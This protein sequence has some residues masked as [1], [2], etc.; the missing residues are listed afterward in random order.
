LPGPQQKPP[1]PKNRSKKTRQPPRTT[2][3]R[4]PK[5]KNEPTAKKQI[6][7]NT[8]NKR[9]QG[10]EKKR[11]H[12]YK[13]QRNKARHHEQGK[14]TEKPRKER[15]TKKK[16][17]TK[18]NDR[19]FEPTKKHTMPEGKRRGNLPAKTRQKREHQIKELLCTGLTPRQIWSYLKKEGETSGEP[20][21]IKESSIHHWTRRAEAQLA[22]ESKIN[23]ETELGKATHRLNQ[24]FAQATKEKDHRT[25]LAIQKEINELHGLK[26]PTQTAIDLTTKGESLKSKPD[27]SQLTDEELKQIETIQRRLTTET[28]ASQ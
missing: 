5:Q 10:K 6:N 1:P 18:K 3:T 27:L 7:N 4:T 26:A 8:R 16:K 22:A 15:K 11:T 13:K 28:Q 19:I 20:F 17:Q 12:P 24:L 2:T 25:A 9:T 23:R 14:T 21:D